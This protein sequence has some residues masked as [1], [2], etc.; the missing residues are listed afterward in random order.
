MT[1]SAVPGAPQTTRYHVCVDSFITLFVAFVYQVTDAGAMNNKYFLPEI[2]SLGM[3]PN[4]VFSAFEAL[5]YKGR[6]L[7]LW[8]ALDVL[9]MAFVY[10]RYSCPWIV[11]QNKVS[12]QV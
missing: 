2:I 11:G 4:W 6:E 3:D 9:H 5:R 1:P 12:P 7:L 10:S 8:N